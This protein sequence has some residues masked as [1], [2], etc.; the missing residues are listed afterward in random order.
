MRVESF[1]MAGKFSECV[2]PGIGDA[3]QFITMQA[4]G[5]H[6]LVQRLHRCRWQY[7]GCLRGIGLRFAMQGD[8][9][10]VESIVA[11]FV[12]EESLAV[13]CVGV[14][15]DRGDQRFGIHG[16]A[17]GPRR[18]YRRCDRCCYRRYC[19]KRGSYSYRHDSGRAYDSN[20]VLGE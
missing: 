19:G 15:L 10:I 7:A 5:C 8:E 6:A 17:Y 13:Q 14:V 3:R 11:L 1:Q 2:L 16:F 18:S 12:V 4:I 9:G 20:L